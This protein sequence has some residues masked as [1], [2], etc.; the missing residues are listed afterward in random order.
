MA[1]TV[2]PREVRAINGAK[3]GT[4]AQS[5]E[6]LAIRITRH[7][8]ELTDRQRQAITNTLLPYITEQHNCTAS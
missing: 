7:W 1:N 8:D 6:Y 5:P 2:T 4:I 3:G